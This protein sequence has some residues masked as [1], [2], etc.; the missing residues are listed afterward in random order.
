MKHLLTPEIAMALQKGECDYAHLLCDMEIEQAPKIA[1]VTVANLSDNQK[2]G[3]DNLERR[4][5]NAC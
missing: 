1:I 4:L 3:Y 2:L 5:R